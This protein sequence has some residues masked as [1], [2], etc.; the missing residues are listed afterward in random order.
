MIAQVLFL[1]LLHFSQALV[2]HQLALK[3]RDVARVIAENA[4]GLV[5][6]EDDFVAFR[7]NLDEVIRIWNHTDAKLKALFYDA[8]RDPF[9]GAKRPMAYIWASNIKELIAN[10]AKSIAAKP[11]EAHAPKAAAN[12]PATANIA[13]DEYPAF[14][15]RH[16]DVGAVQ[17]IY[18]AFNPIRPIGPDA[19]NAV[20]YPAFVPS[21]RDKTAYIKMPDGS[22]RP[23]DTDEY[24]L[25]GV[26]IG[27]NEAIGR[28]FVK[29]GDYGFVCDADKEI[30][31]SISNKMLKMFKEEQPM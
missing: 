23:F 31:I 1:P 9:D 28:F 10:G 26:P 29:G 21:K 2:A 19:G 6:L 3:E 11:K 13:S 25:T 18:P 12:S 5:F 14:R 16:V 27:N 8:F 22:T 4:T 15:P 7:K 17:D 20:L 24:V 30:Q